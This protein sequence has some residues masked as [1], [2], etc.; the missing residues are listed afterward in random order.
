MSRG[1]ARGTLTMA[2]SFSRPKA[3]PPR[4]RTMKFSDLLATCGNGCAGS[5]PTGI[6]S[7][8]T[9]RRKYSRTQR[10]CAAVRSPWE[11]M[12][13]PRAANAGTSESL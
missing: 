9:S 2:I 8:R 3:S 4:R 1:R 6:S 7:G 11:T 13:M 5:S 10:R 12:R